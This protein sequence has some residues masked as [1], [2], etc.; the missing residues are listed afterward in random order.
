MDSTIAYVPPLYTVETD[1]V[2][3]EVLIMVNM[4]DLVL[5]KF[6]FSLDSPHG[7]WPIGDTYINYIC[8]RVTLRAQDRPAGEEGLSI[9]W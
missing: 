7:N 1:Y 2:I 8:R 6:V 9:L 4:I 3:Y 5:K